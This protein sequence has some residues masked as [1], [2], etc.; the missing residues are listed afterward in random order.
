MMHQDGRRGGVLKGALIGFGNVALQAHLP[1]FRQNKHFRIDVVVEPDPERAR[2]ARELIP[3]VSVYT[4]I[5]PAILRN[6]LDF[7]DI[8]T[9]SHSH[10][11]LAE[12]ACRAGLH[13][14]CEKPLV[15][16]IEG[17][18]RIE[19]AKASGCVLFTVNNWK[20]APLWI[21]TRELLSE[22]RLGSV[23]SVS[24]TVLRPPNSGGG[25]SDW[26][27]RAETAGGGILLDHGWHQLYLLRSVMNKTPVV[28]SAKME[29]AGNIEET[30]DVLI[31][32]HAGE[33][34][35]H[36]TWRASLRQNRGEI[37]AEN[38]TLLI[39]DDHLVALA[40]GSPETRHDFAEA[41][42][43]G[44]H[45][46]AWMERVVEDFRREIS[47]ETVCGANLAEARWCARL[48]HCAYQS[49][50]EGSRDVRVDNFAT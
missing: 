45:H 19:A 7:V 27:R 23:V 49:S 35:L 37:K 38:G 21:K 20:H 39:N 28:V 2:L 24:L 43:G 29:Y 30:A 4:D 42:S 22:K 33:A 36:L 31:Q 46:P 34:R 10:A 12:K 14:L 48:I 26:R 3:G 6:A 18:E 13:V 32:F 16:S 40:S 50:R 8:C 15:T 9:P 17:L 47:D 1:A 5:E 25:I 44:S 11:D 41:L